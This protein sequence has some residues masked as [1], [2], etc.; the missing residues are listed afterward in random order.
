MGWLDTI[1]IALATW[2]LTSIVFREEIA[3]PLRGL[4]GGKW[5][6]TLES[7]VYQETFLGSLFSCF[8]CL[9]VWMAF[10]ILLTFLIFPPV[11]Y[12][13]AFSTAAI[14]IERYT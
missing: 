10:I 1:L 4:A 8:W 11:V 9:S 5:D 2:R 12:V 13:L 7:T 6:E 3:R 14:I